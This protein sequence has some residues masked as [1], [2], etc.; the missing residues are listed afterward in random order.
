M[1]LHRGTSLAVLAAGLAFAAP[2]AQATTTCSLEPGGI[3]DVHMDQNLDSARFSVEGGTI[4]VRNHTTQ[5]EVC[6]NG[7]ATVTNTDTVIVTDDSDDPGTPAAGDGSTEARMTAP[8]DFA[9]GKTQEQG[10]D[11][12]SE[13]EFIVNL[14]AGQSDLFQVVGTPGPDSYVVGTGGINWNPNSGDPAPDADLN[15]FSQF[16][17][18]MFVTGAGDDTVN[19]QGGLGTG[20]PFNGPGQLEVHTEGDNDTLRGGNAPTGETLDG[21]PGNDDSQGFGGDDKFFADAAGDDKVDGGPGAHD[22]VGFLGAS[23]PATL[24][25]A[26]AGP[27]QTGYGND[28]F[29]GIED[30]L[31]SDGA[32]TLTG[33][34]GPNVLNGAQ[35]NDTLDGRG[36]NDKLIGSSD[37]DTVTYAEAPAG[38]TASLIGGTASGGAGTDTLVEVENLVGSAFSDNLVGSNLAN[39]ITPGAGADAVSALGGA[40]TVNIRDGES[41]LATCGSEIDTATADRASEDTVD[42]DCENT[43]FLPEPPAATPDTGAG[44]GGAATMRGAQLDFRL[45]GANRQRVLKQKGVVLTA[46]CPQAA[47]T[48][49]ATS[50]GRFGT[51]PLSLKL[52]AGETRTLKLKIGKKRLR[53]LRR[54][55][56]AG[57]KPK[58]QVTVAAIDAAG[59]RA[60]RAL[61][62]AVKR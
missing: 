9:P 35:G 59:A 21:G 52:R 10:N 33:D 42:P 25:L 30:V 18:W 51:K 32:D 54:T 14:N 57:K 49:V 41:D 27:Q 38:V 23:T 5:Q 16:D 29:T 47:C 11:A 22:E 4:T 43:S 36:G 46:R 61:T 48:L 28:T 24:D 2:A 44:A 26:K 13:I 3:L 15:L 55:L 40:D 19:A 34:A 7:P 62:V 45:T 50:S 6:A 37:T 53:S 56:K 20:S 17:R 60:A 8:A 39:S 12:F 1:G 31:G 58:L